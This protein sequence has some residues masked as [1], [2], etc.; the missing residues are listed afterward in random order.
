MLALRARGGPVPNP[1][2]RSGGGLSFTSAA[3]RSDAS[4]TASPTSFLRG[5][6]RPAAAGRRNVSP[7]VD[8]RGPIRKR[9]RLAARTPVQIDISKHRGHAASSTSLRWHRVLP[10]LTRKRMNFAPGYDR[11]RL[12]ERG[13]LHPSKSGGSRFLGI[14]WK[15]DLGI[16]G[17]IASWNWH[18]CRHSLWV[19]PEPT[20]QAA[21]CS[22]FFFASRTRENLNDFPISRRY[23]T[24]LC[25]WS[26]IISWANDRTVLYSSEDRNTADETAR[27]PC[28]YQCCTHCAIEH[29][30]CATGKNSYGWCSLACRQLL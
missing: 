14:W 5:H 19:P 23:G 26:W 11:G 6:D 13:R 17:G 4:R 27:F 24:Q 3:L 29:R 21:R 22:G 8:G 7:T 2:R 16:E 12:L 20:P 10:L 9:H 30:S 25:H 28:S 18:S 15:N 1:A